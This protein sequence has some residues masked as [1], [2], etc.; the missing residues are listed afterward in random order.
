MSKPKLVILLT[1]LIDVIGIGIIVPVLPFYVESFGAKPFTITL[2]FGIFSLFSFLS[3]PF[4]GALSD[5]IGRKPVLI[6]SL[7]STSIGWLVFSFARSIPILFIG[8]I[9]DG[10]AAGNF[11][12]AQSYLVDIS[13]DSKERTANLGLIGASFGIGFIVGPIIGGL[14][15]NISH[16][17]PFLVVG[18]MAGINSILAWIFLPET[19]SKANRNEGVVSINPLRPLL[20]AIKSREL[21]PS[22][23]SWTLFGLAAG[24][25]QSVYAMYLQRTFG[26]TEFLVGLV[27]TITGVG[28]AINQG[29]AMK[30]FWLKK[31][32][33]PDL[34]FSMILF[35]GLGF[36]LISIPSLVFF[37]LGTLIMTFGQSVLRVVM[38]S[39]ISGG[40][41]DNERGE[42]LGVT[43][44][45]TSFSM[46]IA[47]VIAGF[48]FTYGR[49]LP[50][51][52]SG[53]YMF[54]S[55]II[56]YFGR[57]KIAKL[58]FSENPEDNL[59][60]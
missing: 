27:F 43:S 57:Q 56:V 3:A 34:E 33:E 18:V 8:R 16:T 58:K 44:A 23:A 47:P 29:F 31:F 53:M 20:R 59:V 9:I 24:G 39:Q 54:I 22:Y 11:P 37:A 36:I 21:L 42:V 2:L 7:I 50:F 41:K 10:L 46:I 38:I 45:L 4:L 40:A 32:K 49:S 51:L 55:F 19:L 25:M 30:H 15:G 6:I 1:V 14:L 60:T 28:I 52:I 48:A 17:L 35:F 5:R 13:K 12:I 26:F